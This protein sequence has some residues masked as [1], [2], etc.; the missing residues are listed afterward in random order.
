[1]E[2]KIDEKNLNRQRSIRKKIKILLFEKTNAPSDEL[3]KI[4]I[5]S[6][7]PPPLFETPLEIKMIATAPSFHI[8]KK[9][10]FQF[11]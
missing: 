8:Y 9:N 2:K 4:I 11:L 7:E 10:S 6:N 1:M 5:P 3:L